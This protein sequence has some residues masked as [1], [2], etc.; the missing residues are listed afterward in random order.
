MPVSSHTPSR[1]PLQNRDPSACERI[2]IAYG[3][4]YVEFTE[5]TVSVHC[6][7]YRVGRQAPK[8]T[9]LFWTGLKNKCGRLRKEQDLKNNTARYGITNHTF[10]DCKWNDV[11]CIYNHNFPNKNYRQNLCLLPDCCA[12]ARWARPAKRQVKTITCKRCIAIFR[13]LRR[14]QNLLSRRRANDSMNFQ[15]RS[16]LLWYA[17]RDY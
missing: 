9:I 12:A 14:W 7:R 5:D 2:G 16:M 10:V 15:P 4:L 3:I 17:L 1:R 6:S 11:T 8:R 13:S